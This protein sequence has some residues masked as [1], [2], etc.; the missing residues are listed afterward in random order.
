M[1]SEA[2]TPV[3]LTRCLLK[4]RDG[5]HRNSLEGAF[6]S[7]HPGAGQRVFLAS[8][9]VI[10]DLPTLPPKLTPLIACRVWHA[11]GGRKNVIPA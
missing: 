7:S 6:R 3:P 1:S 11:S 5:R 9:R 10:S 8:V 2:F 4:R